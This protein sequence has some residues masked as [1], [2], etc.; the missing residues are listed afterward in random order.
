MPK[1]YKEWLLFS[2]GGQIFIP[3]FQFFG[4]ANKPLIV[5]G[6][7]SFIPANM[8]AIGHT[9]YGDPICFQPGSE[10]IIQWDH[11]ENTVFL[12]WDDFFDFLTDAEEDHED[13]E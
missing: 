9:S 2:D 5:R 4:V 3:D 1:A 12:T 6:G 8:F 11:E 7:N 10:E 13:D